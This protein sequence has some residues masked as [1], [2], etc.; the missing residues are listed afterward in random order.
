MNPNASTTRI[1]RR[2]P[3]LVLLLVLPVA[4]AGQQPGPGI[5]LV[6]HLT[7]D[8]V[9]PELLER[10]SASCRDRGAI[11]PVGR[12]AVPLFRNADMRIPMA[13]P[14]VSRRRVDRR[15]DVVPLAPTLAELLG[16]TLTEPLDGR[17]LAEVVGDPRS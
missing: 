9:R 16:I 15:V 3:G 7:I 6:V 2:L 8:Q 5:R 13:A 10:R 12:A 11:L 4:L 17:P 14:G 1:R